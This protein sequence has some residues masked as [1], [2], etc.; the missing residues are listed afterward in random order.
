MARK[1]VANTNE[2]IPSASRL[3]GSLRDLGYDFVQAVADVVDNSLAAQANK[4]NIDVVFDGAASFVRVADNG[5]GMSRKELLEA[6]R[7]GSHREYSQ[8]DLGRFGLGL[9]T[10]SLSQCRQLAVASR[11]DPNRRR[12]S[13]LAWDLDHLERTDEWQVLSLAGAA[14]S[15]ELAQPLAKH[16]GTVVLWRS[17]DRILDYANP[18]GEPARK[19]VLNMCRQLE[20]H[21]SMVFHRFLSGEARGKRLCLVLNG[22]PVTPWDPFARNEAKTRQMKTVEI[23]LEHEGAGGVIRLERFILPH[24]SEFSSPEAFRAASGPAKWNQQQGFYIYRSG[25]LLQAGGWSGLRTRDEHTKLARCGLYFLPKL[26]DAFRV[27]VAK[28]RVQLPPAARD[29]IKQYV[30]EALRTAQQRYR[31]PSPKPAAAGKRTPAATPAPASETKGQRNTGA[32]SSPP[33][34]S[35]AEGRWT[36]DEFEEELMLIARPK[37]KRVIKAV[38]RRFRKK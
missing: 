33:P 13:A 36:V 15:D 14:I 19:R 18:D 5:C 34:A 8:Q 21:L 7:F 23:P 32:N 27:N 16:R 6:M 22:N 24:E 28:M 25:R 3:V 4:V 11:N 1:T 17:L 26:D 20:A 31:N 30:Q 10:A 2:V 12:I 9:K 29:E 38:M 37:E 35:P